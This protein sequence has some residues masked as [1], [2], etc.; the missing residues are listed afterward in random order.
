MW[1]SL[2]RLF[3]DVVPCNL[4]LPSTYIHKRPTSHFFVS[5]WCNLHYIW[6]IGWQNLLILQ[7]ITLQFKCED[8]CFMKANYDKMQSTNVGLKHLTITILHKKGS[9]VSASAR[10][11]K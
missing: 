8:Y 2:L 4:V 6:T 1:G 11:V 7:I 5:D 3:S 10:T 9:I